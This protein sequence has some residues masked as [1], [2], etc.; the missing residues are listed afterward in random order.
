[1]RNLASAL[2]PLGLLGALA[3]LTFWLSRAVELPEP[4]RSGQFRHDPDYVVDKFTVRKLD[5]QGVLQHV[6]QADQ[7]QHFPD[8]DNSEVAHPKAQ[9]LKPGQP[10]T[11]MSA[12][13]GT[14]NSDASVVELRNNV[15]IHRDATADREAMDG[16]APDLTIYPD[17]ETAHTKSPVR[18]AQGKTWIAGTGLDLDNATMTTILHSRVTGEFASKYRKH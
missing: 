1:M 14:I 15:H 16:S 8:T 9:F 6:M 2:F 4:D 11:T 18:M 13:W 3:A 17:A 12:D 5:K 10:T 7:M